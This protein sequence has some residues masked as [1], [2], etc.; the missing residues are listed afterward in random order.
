MRGSPKNLTP[1]RTHPY[2]LTGYATQT[3]KRLAGLL[4]EPPSK[5]PRQQTYRFIEILTGNIASFNAF[6]L[7]NWHLT[8]SQ[9]GLA[10]LQGAQNCN[11]QDSLWHFEV[12]VVSYS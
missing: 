4:G 10:I 9:L 11:R 3:L 5:T 6:R 12:R 2:S 8:P 7:G 1:F